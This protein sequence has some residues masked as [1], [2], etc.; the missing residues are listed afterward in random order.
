MSLFHDVM[1]YLKIVSC[2]TC[3][4]LDL[5]D[6]IPDKR[7]IVDRGVNT[8][9]KVRVFNESEGLGFFMLY[10]FRSFKG[11]DTHNWS[12]KACMSAKYVFW[13]VQQI[14]WREWEIYYILCKKEHGV[15]QC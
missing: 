14:I 5:R 2:L 10:W 13:R 6:F 4:R 11:F 7:I 12:S 9:S 15:L 3:C 1:Y 8:L